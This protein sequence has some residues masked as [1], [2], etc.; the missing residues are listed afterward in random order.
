MVVKTYSIDEDVAE[1]FKHKTPAQ[2]TSAVLEQLMR[3]YIGDTEDVELALD[4]NKTNLNE[5]QT[6]LLKELLLHNKPKVSRS[7]F[8]KLAKK[9]NI[10]TESRWFKHAAKK[11]VAS[12]KIPVEKNG[13][14]FELEKIDCPNCGFDN[15]TDILVQENGKC[16]ECGAKILK[17]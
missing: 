10:Y 17:L 11:I 8:F 2:E 9:N 15:Y 7:E 5:K 4:L 6:K 3:E 12:D 13:A 1:D 14:K 16:D